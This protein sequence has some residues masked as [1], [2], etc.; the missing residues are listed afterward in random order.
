MMPLSISGV[1]EKVR[2]G[3]LLL[4][5]TSESSGN[6]YFKF[7]DGDPERFITGSIVVLAIVYRYAVIQVCSIFVRYYY[8]I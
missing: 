8:T 4:L 6:E 7:D 2:S 5:P 3:D 1:M